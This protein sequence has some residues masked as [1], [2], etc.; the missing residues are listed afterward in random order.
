MSVICSSLEETIAFGEKLGTLLRA[1][2]VIALRG[3]LGIG[4]TQLVH[5]IANTYLD[6]NVHVCSPSFTII[7]RYEGKGRTIHHLDL[8]RLSTLEELESTGYWDVIE[9]PDAL[10]LIEWLEQV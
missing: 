7:N 4:K 9:D 8:Y 1:G 2:D 5:G 6:A 3:H 10:I